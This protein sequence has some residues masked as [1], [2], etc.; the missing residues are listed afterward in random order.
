ML[1]RLLREE[2]TVS[3]TLT[4]FHYCLV[5]QAY[6]LQDPRQ[7]WALSLHRSSHSFS[8]TPRT[9]KPEALN[10]IL[11]VP[12]TESVCVCVC[13]RVCMC[14]EVGSITSADIVAL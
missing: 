3:V 7:F 6:S 1:R 4:L 13:V 8:K 9:G 2:V 11:R 12:H 10:M 5:L 14:V